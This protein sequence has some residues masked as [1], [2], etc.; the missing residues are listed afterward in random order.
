MALKVCKAIGPQPPPQ[1]SA[2][3]GKNC[4]PSAPQLASVFW[5]EPFLTSYSTTACWP[6]AAVWARDP[7]RMPEVTARSKAAGPSS[8]QLPIHTSAGRLPGP[9]RPPSSGAPPSSGRGGRRPGFST[10]V[11]NPAACERAATSVHR[12]W[13]CFVR[14]PFY[15]IYKNPRAIL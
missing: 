1:A 11:W 6:L 9:V 2:T 7:S 3:M 12:L 8:P 10:S 4:K 14:S 13:W 5:W 15:K